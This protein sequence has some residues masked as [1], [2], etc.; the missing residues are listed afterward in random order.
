MSFLRQYYDEV[1]KIFA[2]NYQNQLSAAD[3]RY[4][5]S[6]QDAMITAQKL[7]I[8]Q[9]KNRQNRIFFISIL[10][11]VLA[12]V[13]FFGIYFR[14]RRRNREAKAAL[15]LEQREAE[16]LREL[17]QMKSRFFTNI[18]HEL[19]T[20]LT[21]ISGPIEKALEETHDTRIKPDLKLVKSNS[22]KLLGLI[23][24]ILDLSKIESGKIVFV[25]N[26]VNLHALIKRIFFSFE[27]LAQIHDLELILENQFPKDEL[28]IL[29]VAKFEK[30]LN[31]LISNA[32]KF[33]RQNGT[34][35]MTAVEELGYAA[36][37]G[38]RFR[39]G[40]SSR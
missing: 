3:A 11:I 22:Q 10:T 32:I 36:C 31:N 40:H 6:Q 24:E 21:L 23:N 37:I 34:V 9:Q 25:E 39:R 18:S 38:R 35:K 1:E 5:S 13:V 29:D 8:E 33:S 2:D 17:D 15:A 27:S 4:R 14:I 26:Q 16:R 30:I 28:I 19:R 7:E 20:P 12:M